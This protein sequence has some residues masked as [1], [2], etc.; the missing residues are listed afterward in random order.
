MERLWVNSADSHVLEPPEIWQE[1]PDALRDRGP[2]SV[3]ED[4]LVSNVRRGENGGRTLRHDGV[5]RSLSTLG[6]SPGDRRDWSAT[7]L[8]PMK[9]D[10]KR[11]DIR[12]VGF[13]QERKTRR[14]VGAATAKLQAS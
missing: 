1:L 7:G 6:A 2:K 13:L 4:N 11:N 10:W 12:I 8:L 14:I 3:V 9:P 5:V